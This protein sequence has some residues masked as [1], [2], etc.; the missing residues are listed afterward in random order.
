VAKI[1]YALSFWG[2]CQ[3]AYID[4]LIYLNFGLLI[5]LFFHL[6]IAIFLMLTWSMST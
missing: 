3:V 2:I 4:D 5:W 1:Q 6:H